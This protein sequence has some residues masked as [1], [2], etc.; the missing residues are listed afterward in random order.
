MVDMLVLLFE[1]RRGEKWAWDFAS[2]L[3]NMLYNIFLGLEKMSSIE[4]L[5]SS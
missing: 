3:G 2:D 4:N 1:T 5:E